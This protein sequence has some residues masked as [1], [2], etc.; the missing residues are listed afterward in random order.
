MHALVGDALFAHRAVGVLQAEDTAVGGR[1]ADRSLRCA[2]G[3]FCARDAHVDRIIAHATERAVAVDDALHAGAGVDVTD[4][5]GAVIARRTFDA[6]PKVGVAHLVARTV[7][8]RLALRTASG[9]ASARRV[10]HRIVVALQ[11][12]SVRHIADRARGATVAVRRTLDA[13][14][15]KV[16]ACL[17]R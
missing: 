10:A 11:T 12:E 16:G 6:L 2:V 14:V 3:I 13:L 9:D 4:A 17:V 5:V 1:I 15:E 8:V 7:G